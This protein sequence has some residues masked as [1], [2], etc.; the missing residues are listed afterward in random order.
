MDKSHSLAFSAS[1]GKVIGGGVSVGI[2]QDV[3]YIGNKIYILSGGLSFGIGQIAAGAV[4]SGQTTALGG[5]IFQALAHGIT[6]EMMSVMNGGKLGAGFLSGAIS[7]GVSSAVGGPISKLSKTYQAGITITLGG[8]TGGLGAELAGGKFIHGF[9]QGLITSGLNHAEHYLKQTLQN[10]IA[11][12]AEKY[13]GST[14]W[15]LD[16]SIDNFDIGDNKCNKFVYDVLEESGVS[17]GTPNGIFGTSPPSAGQ[18]ADP[19]FDIPGWKVVSDPKRGDVVAYSYNYSDAT[20]H[21]AIVTANSR[22][23]RF[24]VGTSGAFNS[25][26]RTSFGFSYSSHYIPKGASYIYRRY[27]G[28]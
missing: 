5:K 8:I 18:W 17:P 14:K 4:A 27:V 25:I 19:N 13:I 3:D 6:G 15:N 21:V 11:T 28:L 22:S 9:R 1:L 16:V 23:Y 20:G 7:S 10:R 12:I 24:S 2:A 26:A